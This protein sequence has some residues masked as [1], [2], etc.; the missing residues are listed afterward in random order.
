MINKFYHFMFEVNLLTWVL[1]YKLTLDLLY[2]ILQVTSFAYVGYTLNIDYFKIVFGW[3]IYISIFRVIKTNVDNVITL[4]AYTFFALSIAPSVTLYQFYDKCQLWMLMIQVFAL[5]LIYLFS[6]IRFFK[7]TSIKQVSS[8]SFSVSIFVMLYLLIFFIY[9]LCKHGLPS[10]ELLSLY[11]I[12]QVRAIAKISL[13][14]SC[15]MNITCKII[16]PIVI[17][18]S[19]KEHKYLK[20]LIGIFIQLYIYSVTGFKTFLFIPF[21][22]LGAFG[23]RGQEI[24]KVIFMGLS[25]SLCFASLFT[26]ITGDYMLYALIGNRAV[27]LPAIIKCAYFDY[28]S[29]NEFVYFTQNTIAKILGI[30]S[31]YSVSVPNLIGEKYFGDFNMWTNTGFIADAY[32]NMGIIGVLV[33]SILMALILRMAYIS[34]D[35]AE[36]DAKSI[37][38][39]IYLLYFVVLNDGALISTF[40][41]GG[42]IVWVAISV[43]IN[44]NK[45]SFRKNS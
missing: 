40:I 19:C 44:F 45:P 16:I 15:I 11:S 10:F 8:Y 7:N 32:S 18:F 42:L 39:S 2:I 29:K 6:R 3:L 41:S 28:F 13:L 30:Q 36:G 26:F 43:F 35:K 14:E 27:F 4:F 34:M 25:V 9:S 24:K 17:V 23:L 5:L 20:M 38:L 33:I 12:Y 31:N 22:L 1:L 37:L 21:V